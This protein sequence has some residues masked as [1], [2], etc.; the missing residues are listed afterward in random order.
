MNL[1][2]I[3]SLPTKARL[4]NYLHSL[5][6]LVWHLP[7]GNLNTCTYPHITQPNIPIACCLQPDISIVAHI[8]GQTEPAP[9][10]AP[11]GP[12]VQWMGCLFSSRS[13]PLVNEHSTTVNFFFGVLDLSLFVPNPN[14][15][16]YLLPYGPSYPTDLLSYSLDLPTNYN[17]P[18]LPT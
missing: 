3:P 10:T 17:Q 15:H 14:L 13:W 16:T 4:K 8:D 2:T 9:M 5:Y 6:S 11:V 18:P 7:F 12:S 1:N